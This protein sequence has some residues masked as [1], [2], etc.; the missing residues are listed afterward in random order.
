MS[1]NENLTCTEHSNMPITNFCSATECFK[2]LC[3][4]CIE[5]HYKYHKKINTSPQITS[6]RNI[7]L[8]CLE[9]I[10][11]IIISLNQEIEKCELDYILDP[12][13]IIKE[14]LQK[15][16]SFKE[17][18]FE[19]I[20]SY[21]NAVEKNFIKTAKENLLQSTDFK[22]IFDHM[23][24]VIKDLDYTRNKLENTNKLDPIKKI[25]ILDIKHL[26]E[27]F[28]KEIHTIMD[29]KSI[30]PINI[31]INE[32]RIQ[33]Y[34]QKEMEK[35]LTLEKIPINNE[36]KEIGEDEESKEFTL[37]TPQKTT[38]IKGIKIDYMKASPKNKLFI[39]SLQKKQKQ[40][41][42]AIGKFN[43]TLDDY[44]YDQEKKEPLLHFF[45]NDSKNLYILNL[46]DL[47]RDKINKFKKVELDIDFNIPTFHKSIILPNGEIYL[48]GGSFENEDNNK[49]QNIFK[50]TPQTKKLEI[51]GK[52]YY[53]RSSHA[54]CFSHPFI[55]VVGG[56]G[57]DKNILEKCEKFHIE[58]GE[59]EE[60][61]PLNY[62]VACTCICSFFQDYL[63][64]FG[65]NCYSSDGENILSQIIEKYDIIKDKWYVLNVSVVPIISEQYNSFYKNDQLT[66]KTFFG[67]LSTAACCQIN[68][69]EILVM[70][71]YFE[72]NI[73]SNQTFS[74]NVD[75]S[76]MES[77]ENCYINNIGRINLPFAE[78]FWNNSAV[79]YKRKLYVLQN[80]AN[81][82][83]EEN[84]LEDDRKI[85]EFDCWKWTALN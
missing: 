64:K 14:G 75:Y 65:G 72:N 20:K 66:S 17:K 40:T 34:F 35:L 36:E 44:Y 85:L 49:S 27:K 39:N 67:L 51:S 31:S 42:H 1:S 58:T 22:K 13:K 59:V 43:I 15:I 16:N 61:C 63:F 48:I 73:G 81:P 4:E 46:E 21:C 74:F 71:G 6:L 50:Y 38:K 60:I 9:K 29:S 11:A 33:N 55:Y 18:I 23:K 37:C 47:T 2:E 3:P 62:P 25:S 78:G 54:L 5:N 45:Q 69:S 10:K 56:I 12:D 80:I 26:I 57:K 68:Q 83:K 53:P 79:I 19:I 28:R 77:D 30:F 24:N 8:K 84:C 70:G 41:Y 7:K 52:L 82:E 32:N 76:D